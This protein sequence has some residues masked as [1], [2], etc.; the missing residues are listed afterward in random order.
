MGDETKD[1]DSLITVNVPMKD[2]FGLGEVAN[3]ESAKALAK[4]VEPGV[5]GVTGALTELV[6]GTIHRY[7][8]TKDMKILAKLSEMSKDTSIV[9]VMQSRILYREIDKQLNIENILKEAIKISNNDDRI[10]ISEVDSDFVRTFFSESENVSSEE[11]QKIWATLIAEAPH[12]QNGSIPKPV[13]NMLKNFDK[14]I[15]GYFFDY[16]RFMHYF[17]VPSVYLEKIEQKFNFNINFELLKEIGIIQS[18]DAGWLRIGDVKIIPFPK[19]NREKFPIMAF[20]SIWTP[21]YIGLEIINIINKTIDYK[22]LYRNNYDILLECSLKK[23][24]SKNEKYQFLKL[25][26]EGSEDVDLI[27]TYDNFLSAKYDIIQEYNQVSSAIDNIS[28]NND[29]LKK[30]LY[31][32]LEAQRAGIASF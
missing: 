25:E 8:V 6:A 1:K 24:F 22:D 15:A 9:S 13:T 23:L 11:V 10:P 5:R 17:G 2:M 21:T 14:E 27:L 19:D 30:V 12:R 26:K 16:M 29:L 4:A 3:S 28:S 31:K 32:F 18:L 20:C 7:N